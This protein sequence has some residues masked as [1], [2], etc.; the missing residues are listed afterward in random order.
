M[1]SDLD[2]SLRFAA[3]NLEVSFGDLEG[4][5]A[6]SE[7]WIVRLAGQGAEVVAFPELSITGYGRTDAISPVLQQI[8]GSLTDRLTSIAQRADVLILAGA[9]TVDS[10]GDRQISHLAVSG[11][12]LLGVYQKIYLSPA[13]A[14]FYSPG[15]IPLVVSY[16]GWQIGI[17]LC[18][19][20]HFPGLSR[21]Q[22]AQGADVLFMGFATPKHHGSE[23]CQRLMRYLPARAYDNSCYVIS[24]NLRGVGASGRQYPGGA[25]GIDPKGRLVEIRSGGEDNYLLMDL[26][27]AELSRI[28][29]NPKAYFLAHDQDWNVGGVHNGRDHK[30]EAD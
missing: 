26:A 9:A 15:Q 23:V 2:R 12:G 16:R 18:Y 21:A 11:Q 14:E 29:G 7:E 17:Q 22:A 13:E 24:C 19:D 6:R 10:N 1:F 30:T 27:A 25:L 4:N 5:L 28:R 20:T 3:V 8:P